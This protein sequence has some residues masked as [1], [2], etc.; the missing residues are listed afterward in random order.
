MEL[1]KTIEVLENSIEV[2]LYIKLVNPQDIKDI[3]DYLRELAAYRNEGKHKNPVGKATVNRLVPESHFTDPVYVIESFQRV[4]KDYNE[5]AV[6]HKDEGYPKI[7][8][9][10]EPHKNNN[11]PI[12]STMKIN[13]EIKFPL[14]DEKINSK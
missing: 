9:T 2:P 5:L 10:V 12:M 1:I 3:V 8:L 11:Y 13:L 7:E 6:A 14:Q 4:I